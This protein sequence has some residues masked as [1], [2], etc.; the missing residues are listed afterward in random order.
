MKNSILFI[1]CLLFSGFIAAQTTDSLSVKKTEELVVDQTVA[2]EP[3]D[4]LRPSRAAFYSAVLPGLGQAYNKRYWKIPIIYAGMAAGI[5]FHI[6]NDK[7]YDRFRN[8][9]KRRLA[10]FTDDEFF[11]D[12]ETPIISNER[13][14]NAQETAQ[15]NKDVSIIVALAFYLVNIVDANVDAHLRQFNVSEDLSI[16]PNFEIDPI[17]V[18]AN[19]GL[20]LKFNLE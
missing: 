12:G 3:Y 17:R 18:Q 10:G 13:L 15:K 2:K 11:G 19:Y 1:L 20:S 14:I 4:P 6:Q 9:Y 7:D 8:A 16:S 5:Y